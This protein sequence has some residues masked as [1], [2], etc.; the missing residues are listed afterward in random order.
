MTVGRKVEVVRT[1]L[2]LNSSAAFRPA[3]LVDAAVTLER[4]P[5][6]TVELS[7]RLYHE[8]GEAYHWVDRL[9]WT[10]T[11][12][13]AYLTQA[14]FG[15]WLMR[16]DRKVAGF[17][18]L[19]TD[20]DKSIEIALFGLL[21]EFVGRGLGKHLLS[22]AVDEAWVMGASRVWLH[23]CTLDSPVALPN[24]VARGFV[25]YRKEAYEAEFS[26]A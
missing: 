23:T 11:E 1:Y 24:Y 2:E 20:A 6:C 3:R 5:R 13:D 21:T 14:G 12:L 26:S 16:Y 19:R 7:R 8:V 10:D 22:C 17:F 18:E 4:V 15:V 9:A 25:P